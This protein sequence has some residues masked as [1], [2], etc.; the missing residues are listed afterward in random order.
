M[1]KELFRVLNKRDL[2]HAVEVASKAFID[3]PLWVYL[4]P[5]LK[6]REK[7]SLRFFKALLSYSIDK[8]EA[9][10]VGTPVKAVALWKKYGSV[11]GSQ[12]EKKKRLSMRTF[13]GMSNMILSGF[14]YS[15]FKIRK[16]MKDIYYMRRL[17]APR[18]HHYLH[19][20]CVHPDEQGRGHATTILKALLERGHTQKAP[21]YLET[22]TPINVTFY[23]HMGFDCIKH[24]Q[25]KD[26][27]LEVW[28]FLQV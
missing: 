1:S 3:D 5:D 15:F 20:L 6:R 9:Y 14:L 22:L 2:G 11:K 8:G 19:M 17:L 23:Q 12:E 24:L 16:L 18:P 26:T 7:Y 4:Y 27:G 25:Y 13:I 10:G 21:W 28:T